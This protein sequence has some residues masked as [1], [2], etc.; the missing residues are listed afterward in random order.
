MPQGGM[1]ETPM[2]RVLV[3]DS[4]TWRTNA[5]RVESSDKVPYQLR[6]VSRVA[7]LGETLLL[8]WDVVIVSGYLEVFNS[9]LTGM[10]LVA[11]AYEKA[12]GAGSK[13]WGGCWPII[14]NATLTAEGEEIV[15]FFKVKGIPCAFIPFCWQNPAERK[16][17][18]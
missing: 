8:K 13:K 6:I 5:F 16:R 1:A 17:L 12:L 3:V 11:S 9:P 15:K 2:F 10:D 18:A 4:S 14:C 7:Q